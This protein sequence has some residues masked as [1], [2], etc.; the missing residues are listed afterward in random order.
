MIEETND[1]YVSITDRGVI[2]NVEYIVYWDSISGD[3][4]RINGTCSM[5]GSC[6]VGSSDTKAPILDC[7][8]RPEIS[9]NEF[10][11]LSGVYL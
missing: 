11:T 10:C 2:N 3:R 1:P 8:V 9:K 7:P 6:W 5:C 4:W